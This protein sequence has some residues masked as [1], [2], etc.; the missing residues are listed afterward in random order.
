MVIISDRAK[1]LDSA[2]PTYLSQATYCHCAYHIQN[3]LMEKFHPS[4]KVRKLFWQAVYAPLE[5][6]FETYLKQIEVINAA[7]GQYLREIPAKT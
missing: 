7:T 1:G 6:L 4:D 5:S 3:N 2:I